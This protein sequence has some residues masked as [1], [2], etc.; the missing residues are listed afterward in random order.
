MLVKKSTLMTVHTVVDQEKTKNRNEMPVQKNLR[1]FFPI[2]M[3]VEP[4]RKVNM[5]CKPPS[6]EFTSKATMKFIYDKHVTTGGSVEEDIEPTSKENPPPS[7]SPNSCIQ[8]LPLLLS[9]FFNH[10]T[11]PLSIHKG[12][13]RPGGSAKRKSVNPTKLHKH[14]LSQHCQRLTS[15][16]SVKCV[17]ITR[18]IQI[19][20]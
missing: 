20:P 8:G 19:T 7:S 5:A 4:K 11:S 2:V 10:Q 18:E 3:K 1:K 6:L 12:N 9:P 16:S 17:F 15:L 13:G 14:I